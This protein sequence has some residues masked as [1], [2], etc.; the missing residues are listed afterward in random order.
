MTVIRIMNLNCLCDKGGGYLQ[1]YFD[2]R[3]IMYDHQIYESVVQTS[4]GGVLH[5]ILT[6]LSNP[7]HPVHVLMGNT[8]S[9]TYQ[10]IVLKDHLAILAFLFN[11]N[12]Q[13]DRWII[14]INKQ[15]NKQILIQNFG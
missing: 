4:N 13:N 2:G 1:I 11:I 9:P 5:H 15:T 7:S 3:T 8:L 10:R 12:R 6:N 14:I